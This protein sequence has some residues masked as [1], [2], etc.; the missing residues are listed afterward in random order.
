MQAKRLCLDPAASASSGASSSSSGADNSMDKHAI[1]YKSTWEAD[2][3]WLSPVR[4]SEGDV[5]GML[6]DVCKKHKTKNKY[7]QSAVWSKV[8]CVSLRRDSVRRHSQ[9]QQHKDALELEMHAEESRRTGGIRQAFET[10]MT[11]NR[12][13]MMAA[14][15]CLYWLVKSEIPHT[16]HYNSLLKAV[17]FMGCEPLKHLNHGDNAKYTSQRIIQEFLQVIGEQLEQEILENLLSSPLYSIMIDETTDVAIIKE[18][19]IYALYL[20]SGGKVVTS[21]LSI[22]Q[23]PDGKANTMEDHLIVYL[24]SKHIPL[25]RLVGFGSDGAAVMTGKHTGVAARLKQRQPILTSVHCI[26]HRLALA[27]SQSG[28]GISYISKTFKPTLRQLFYF[29]ENSAVRMSGLKAIEHLLQTPELKLKKPLDT[30]W[31]SHDAACQTLVKVLP[32]VITSLEREA[33]ERGDALAIGLCK[34]VKQYNFISTLYM[35]CDI[36]P[37]VSRLSRMFQSS[38]IDLGMMDSLVSSTIQ[39]LELLKQQDGMF[40]KQLESDLSSSL[41][42]FSIH[43]SSEMKERFQR[44][45]LQNFLQVLTQNIKQRFPD[46]GMYANFEI[47]NPGKLPQTAELGMEHEYGEKAVEELGKF[48]GIG[49]TPLV[50]SEMLNVEWCDLRTYMILN[51]RNKTMK[52]VLIALSDNESVLST[53]YPN[54]CKLAQVCLLLPLNTA[55]CERAFSTMRR[56]KSRLG[57]QMNN[58]TLNHCMRISMEG[59]PLE[60]FDFNKS[61]DTWSRLRNRRI[62]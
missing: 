62:L 39:S 33:S 41:A 37:P 20:T 27:A 5:V 23:L 3:S 34:V 61:V 35:M 44:C 22:I 30:R 50:D 13:A 25:S 45:I 38:T 56:V 2:Y 53:V 59:H 40:A 55:D 18:M 9:S 26:A 60:V 28:E 46:T 49:D 42:P 15:E 12:S 8:P 7:N 36:L 1:G 11:L 24:E 19:V 17:E 21:F 29:Y 14:M 6:C 32:A 10:Q 58:S 54:F 43:H 57:S 52:E 48:Y 16:T 47:L 4:N 31:L 51:Y